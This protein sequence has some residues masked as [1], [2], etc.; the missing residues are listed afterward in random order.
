[1]KRHIFFFFCLLS[2]WACKNDD[3]PENGPEEEPELSEQI[4]LQ[5]RNLKIPVEIENN[6]VFSYTLSLPAGY[7]GIVFW[8]IDD[9]EMPSH[10]ITV[11]LFELICI[12]Y[13]VD[14]RLF[15]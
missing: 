1:M 9:V 8:A 13:V 14:A 5:I 2:F 11:T 6:T 10:Y 3:A 4:T 7:S 15:V 12:C